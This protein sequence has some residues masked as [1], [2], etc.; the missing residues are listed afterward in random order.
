MSRRDTETSGSELY[1]RVVSGA[2]TYDGLLTLD[3]KLPLESDH[4]RCS[5]LVHCCDWRLKKTLTRDRCLLTLGD[6][7]EDKI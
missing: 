7:W 6:S 4:S 3:E 5:D 1:I 2:T